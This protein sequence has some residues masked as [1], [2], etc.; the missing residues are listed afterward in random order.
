MQHIIFG[1]FQDDDDDGDDDDDD[2]RINSPDRHCADL[3]TIE[4]SW[5]S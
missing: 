3:P 5:E 4:Q 1:Q 2:D